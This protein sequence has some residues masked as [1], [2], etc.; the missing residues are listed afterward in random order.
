M[1][2]LFHNFSVIS[3]EE[4]YHLTTLCRPHA[5]PFNNSVACSW[6]FRLNFIEKVVSMKGTSRCNL[7]HLSTTS[8][9]SGERVCF[10]FASFCV[11]C[12]TSKSAAGYGTCHALLWAMRYRISQCPASRYEHFSKFEPH[13]CSVYDYLC[14][15]LKALGCHLV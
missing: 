9:F 4:V 11:V 3:E 8:P 15:G 1:T 6:S 7:V 12:Y 2:R 5:S 14:S 10:N 13:L